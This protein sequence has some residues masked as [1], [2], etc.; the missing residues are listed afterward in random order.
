MVNRYL[1]KLAEADC[2]GSATLDTNTTGSAVAP[3]PPP[4][5]KEV[6]RPTYIV[7][8]Q[9]SQ[10]K[11]NQTSDGI[12][13][14]MTKASSDNRYLEKIANMSFGDKMRIY[15]AL[16]GTASLGLGIR[17]VLSEKGSTN[18]QRQSLH[19]LRDIN[20]KLDYNGGLNN[21]AVGV[22]DGTQSPGS[23]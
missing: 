21:N 22:K 8:N 13:Q 7:G 3:P 23:K 17:N 12:Y 15:G 18:T 10:A 11:Y 5:S 14:D 2:P 20:N 9:N 19:V 1:L 16:T 6:L 4:F